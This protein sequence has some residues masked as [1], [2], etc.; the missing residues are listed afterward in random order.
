MTAAAPKPGRRWRWAQW[1]WPLGLLLL[2]WLI[3]P[4][5]AGANYPGMPCAAQADTVFGL[6]SYTILFIPTAAIL[7]LLSRRLIPAARRRGLRA[8]VAGL[9]VFGFAVAIVF[10]AFAG[11]S[12]DRRPFRAS[13]QAINCPT[14][15]G[16]LQALHCWRS[17]ST[18]EMNVSG[19]RPLDVA[20][21]QSMAKTL[22]ASKQDAALYEAFVLDTTD[23]SI[24]NYSNARLF[25]LQD[26]GL[27]DFA[28]LCLSERQAKLRE[29]QTHRVGFYR[30]SAQ[31]SP[32]VDAFF[33]Q[34]TASGGE[35]GYE[36]I[37]FLHGQ[38]TLPYVRPSD[39]QPAESA[40][41]DRVSRSMTTL[42]QDLDRETQSPSPPG[43]LAAMRGDF[44]R[45]TAD[46]ASATPS[47]LVLFRD[48]RVQRFLQNY[49]L[50]LTA[51]ESAA[52][53]QSGQAI[54]S[55]AYQDHRRYYYQE[56]RVAR[57]IGYLYLQQ[58]GHDFTEDVLS[59]VNWAV[60]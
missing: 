46:L 28:D 54:H 4:L 16:G 48:S 47:R 55:T 8:W 5:R 6:A 26:P 32:P 35:V 44:Q 57:L 51:E 22:A 25:I 12:A 58:P 27:T 10:L 53:G 59:T 11:V 39:L 49:D 52:Q 9:F 21:V 41:L 31:Q 45:I 24:A 15:G 50:I 36:V 20:G 43:A 56:A 29:V 34:D 17:G 23:A 18:I 33:L 13:E 19:Q 38:I 37:D 60:F 40:Y 7:L 30:Y 2:A 42:N 14:L 1:T 3:T